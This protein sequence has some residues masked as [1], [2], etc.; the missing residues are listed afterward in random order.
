MRCGGL[1]RKPV[2]KLWII[3]IIP[4]PS[5]AVL[6][7]IFISSLRGNGRWY[8]P[9]GRTWAAFGPEQSL[10]QKQNLSRCARSCRVFVDFECCTV[11]WCGS[12]FLNVFDA[13]LVCLHSTWNMIVLDFRSLTPVWSL[14]ML[15]ELCKTWQGFAHVR[16]MPEASRWVRAGLLV[17]V[18]QSRMEWA[19]EP[20][21][22]LNLGNLWKPWPR[23]EADIWLRHLFAVQARPFPCVELAGSRLMHYDPLIDLRQVELRVDGGQH[24][25]SI[26]HGSIEANGWILIAVAASATFNVVSL[27]RMW[28]NLLPPGQLAGKTP[29]TKHLT[30]ISN[31]IPPHFEVTFIVNDRDTRLKRVPQEHWIELSFKCPLPHEERVSRT[32]P[33]ISPYRQDLEVVFDHGCLRLHQESTPRPSELPEITSRPPGWVS[34]EN[35]PKSNRLHHENIRKS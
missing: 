24:T 10:S 27:R 19:A 31:T 2:G 12:S 1:Q 21:K 30:W 29:E 20:P 18:T 28:G 14:Y 35:P 25:D 33:Q 15:T 16:A 26:I 6:I 32:C 17:S 5:L 8:W 13:C 34:M 3:P 7:V 9:G 22:H 4:G 23:S 11:G